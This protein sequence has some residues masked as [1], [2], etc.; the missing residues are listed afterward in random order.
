MLKN[1]RL[2]SMVLNGKEHSLGYR[3]LTQDMQSLGLRR[4][5][6]IITY[7]FNEWYFLPSGKVEPGKKD[8][9][10]IWVCRLKS[11]G[12]KL[13]DYMKEKHNKETRLFRACLADILY[14]NSYRVK[15]NGI[16]LFEE[17]IEEIIV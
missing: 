9:G 6:N 1:P 2:Q 11:D 17:I 5:P 13:M 16:F 15:T 14:Y 7:P 8:W 10:G 4:N 12:K 3:V